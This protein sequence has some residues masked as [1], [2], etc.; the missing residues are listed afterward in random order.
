MDNLK[1]KTMNKLFLFLSFFFFIGSINAQTAPIKKKAYVDEQKILN[2]EAATPRAGYISAP[3]RKADGNWYEK[4]D[5]GVE[6]LIIDT[7]AMLA[8]KY[9]LQNV[10]IDTLN[11]IATKYDLSNISIDT[12]NEIATKYDI[13]KQL[14][15]YTNIAAIPTTLELGERIKIEDTGA[16][17]FVQNTTV[18]GFNGGFADG[19][20]VIDLGGSKYAVLQQVGSIFDVLH[21]GV[22]GTGDHTS[23]IQKVID[24]SISTSGGIVFLNPSFEYNITS[25]Y[26]RNGINIKGGGYGKNPNTGEEIGTTVNVTSDGMGFI[27]GES[28]FA[29]NIKQRGGIIEGLII[30]GNP[31]ARSGIRIGSDISY[32]NVALFDIRNILIL[33]FTNSNVKQ[34]TYDKTT[35]NLGSL[36][37]AIQP[38]FDFYGACGIFFANGIAGNVQN[39][40]IENSRFGIGESSAKHMTTVSF[41]KIYISQCEIG[42]EIK[43]MLDCNLSESIIESCD[44]SAIRNFVEVT[45]FSDLKSGVINFLIDGLHLESNNQNDVNGFDLVFD[46]QNDGESIKSLIIENSSFSFTENGIYLNRTDNTVIRNCGIPSI[47]SS[48]TFIESENNTGNY[49]VYEGYSNPNFIFNVDANFVFK[50]SRAGTSGAHLNGVTGIAADVR[51]KGNV[52]S[53]S[54]ENI[55]VAGDFIFWSPVNEYRL[56]ENDK[57]SIVITTRGTFAANNNVKTLRLKIGTD[58]ILT[59]TDIIA[60]NGVSWIA[61]IELQ[62]FGQ[63]DVKYNATLKIGNQLESVEYGTLNGANWWTSEHRLYATGQ[64]TVAQSNEI[65]L[66]GI[67][68]IYHSVNF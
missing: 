37:G 20:A 3:Y 45:S 17:Y 65:I 63:N 23:I 51:G 31:F 26:I 29:G 34:I 61:K 53:T 54:E 48:N 16:E 66:Q 27:L 57:G 1:Q 7:V 56:N 4:T 30:K 43:N 62:K 28:T 25:V 21:F 64:A 42:M 14:K 22:S 50:I 15:Y 41:E 40:R 60:P 47:I 68:A 38:A 58:V 55:L 52:A 2:V 12:I 49:N 32:V 44:S 19:V 18:A 10:S 46:N 6:Q 24:F 36:E 13:T 67:S 59:N 8:T 11:E 5:A 33:D 39:V 35:P 9:D